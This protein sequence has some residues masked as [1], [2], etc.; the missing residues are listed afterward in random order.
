MHAVSVLPEKPN[1]VVPQMNS[2]K[3]VIEA[4]TAK[5]ASYATLKN[6][7]A[8]PVQKYPLPVTGNME[9]GFFSTVPLTAT[10]TQL[11][12][13]TKASCDVTQ[14][15]SDYFAMKKHSVYA[16]PSVASGK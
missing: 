2:D 8:L 9:Y 6:T 15:A 13:H 3:A 10:P 4:A 14:Y 7:G 12:N 5:L 11:F 16:N 1:H